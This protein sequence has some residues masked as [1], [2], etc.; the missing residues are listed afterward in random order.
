MPAERALIN[1]D[2]GVEDG[3]AMRVRGLEDAYPNLIRIDEPVAQMDFVAFVVKPGVTP[4]SW[5]ELSPY[6]VAVITGWKIAEANTKSVREITH[7]ASPAQLFS[8]LHKGRADVA[9]FER[10]QGLSYV[11][12]AG[13]TARVVEPPLAST[14]MYLY[15]NRK[16]QALAE[17]VLRTLRAMRADGTLAR[18]AAEALRP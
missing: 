12:V 2:S 10:W 13:G 4:A 9:I 5:K 18:I 8:V 3:E 7:A 16:H 11:K 14:P 6:S 1:A 15:L 17:R